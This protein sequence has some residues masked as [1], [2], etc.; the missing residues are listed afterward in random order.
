MCDSDIELTNHDGTSLIL[1]NMND[2]SD[3]SDEEK[4]L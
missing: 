1:N 2:D 3:D 4:N